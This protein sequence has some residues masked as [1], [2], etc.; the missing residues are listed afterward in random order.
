MNPD[1]SFGHSLAPAAVG[2]VLSLLAGAAFA[3]LSVPQIAKRVLPKP[4][5]T[6]LADFLPFDAIE[7]DGRTVK[8]RDGTV[9]QF[10]AITGVDQNF[11]HENEARTVAL[12]RKQLYDQLAEYGATLRI[13]TLREPVSLISNAEFPNDIAQEISERW[14][15]TFARAFRTQTILCL[16]LK[17]TRE[18]GRMDEAVGL[19][20]S[21]LEPFRPRVL[22]CDPFDSPTQDTTIGSFLG[23]LVSPVG[24][25]SPGSH[26][27]GPAGG[28]AALGAASGGQT[29]DVR[30]LP[31]E[32][33]E[34]L[35][36]DR[37]L[38]DSLRAQDQDERLRRGVGEDTKRALGGLDEYM[39]E[40][41]GALTQDEVTFLK[42]G[43]IRFR[44]GD[45]VKYCS[46]VGLRR[47]G[48]DVNSLLANE[49]AAIPGEMIVHQTVIPQPK[50]ETLLKLK[51]QQR[52]VASTSFSSDVHWQYEAAIGMVEGMDENR[53]TLCLFAE[54][55]FLFSESIEELGAIEKMARQI[56]NAHGI[57]SVRERG[58]SQVCWFNQFPTYDLRPRVYRLM[59]SHVALMATFDRPP[60]G[61]PRSDWGPGPIARFYTGANTVYDHQFH[62]STEPGAVGHGLCIAPTGAG[63]TVLMEFLSVMS[64]RHR[65]LRHFFFDRYQGT[66]IYTT[67]MGG[68]YLGFNA[69]K[70]THSIRGGMNPLQCAQTDEN[71]DFLKNWLQ[72]ISGCNDHDAFEQ[73]SQAIEIGFETLDQDER[74]LAA[75]YEGA[76]A[77]NT[78]LRQ[79]LYKWVDPAQYGA[80]FNAEKDCIDLE[81]GGWLTTFDMTNLFSDPTLAAASVSYVMFRIRQTMSRQNAPAFIFIDE[82]APLLQDPYFKQMYLVMLREFR[83]IG[84]VIVSVFQTPDALKSS[85]ISELVRQQC[86]TYYLFPNPGA[87]DHDYAEFELTDREM[88]FLLGRSAPARRSRRAILVKRP[89]TKESVIVD[90]DLSPLGP[91]LKIFSST[92]KDVKLASELQERFGSAWSA[93]YLDSE[94]P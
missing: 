29:A 73:I 74:S 6:R 41:A 50:G 26:R 76:F 35:K 65:K 59:S 68:K 58:A 57:V 45:D 2:G 46:V 19:V 39:G 77:P 12:A 4:E 79:E 44:C 34:R 94:A 30:R 32:L 66:Y 69:E 47:L 38:M 14:N 37:D 24:K 55:I 18:T 11:L 17:D 87:T 43:L 89:S 75:L 40:L 81:D 56:L 13:F 82:T 51:Q 9:A 22:T 15:H 7:A 53:S 67:A 28:G 49:L 25:P 92:S 83:K 85:G 64:S 72:G 93:R 62:I 52:M 88:S 48:D 78:K 23:R 61:L 8:M 80:M 63:K 70:L 10:I 33:A 21:I 84:G 42:N 20:E 31:P 86:S 71:L 36:T 27:H 60:A 16:S 5:E 90:V 3:A 91:F 54:T 1:V